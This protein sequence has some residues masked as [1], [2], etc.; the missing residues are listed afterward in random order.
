MHDSNLSVS[1]VKKIVHFLLAPASGDSLRFIAQRPH[2]LGFISGKKD[3]SIDLGCGS[4][5][6]GRDLIKTSRFTILSDINLGN[7]LAQQTFNPG[8]ELVRLSLPEL[9]FRGEHFDTVLL[10]EVL[11]H[12]ESDEKLISEIAR[13]LKRKGMLILSVPHPPDLYGTK[14][15]SGG[16]PMGHKREGY[17]YVEIDSLLSRNGFNI[18]KFRYCLFYPARLAIALIRSTQKLFN[19]RPRNMFMMPLV[20]LDLLVPNNKLF[21]PFDIIIRAVKT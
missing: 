15:D 17:T 10:I 12:I 11:E 4:G 16:N 14:I 1:W 9:P 3:K 6:Y 20:M 19:V 5:F 8:C 18:V 21:K 2:I 13:I 7:L